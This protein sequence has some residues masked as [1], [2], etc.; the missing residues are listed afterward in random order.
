MNDFE[1]RVVQY[2]T[3]IKADQSQ[4]AEKIESL[5]ATSRSSTEKIRGDFL[6][7][8]GQVTKLAGEVVT[9]AG[10]VKVL[11][12]SCEV[13]EEDVK[14]LVA[15]FRALDTAIYGLTQ[16]CKTNFDLNTSIQ[17][18]LNVGAGS[19]RPQRKTRPGAG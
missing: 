3:E 18:E 5:A 15:K 13:I 7:L 1:E 9:L 6:A 4:L 19:D 8:Q 2:L 14:G 16:L 10:N 17:K 12:A 11:G